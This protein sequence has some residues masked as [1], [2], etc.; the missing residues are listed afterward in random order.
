MPLLAQPPTNPTA[1]GA[2]RPLNTTH[3]VAA[4][5]YLL[6]S[7]RPPTLCSQLSPPPSPAIPPSP[8]VIEAASRGL[9]TGARAAAYGSGLALAGVALGSLWAARSISGVVGENED[10]IDS[11]GA[12]AAALKQT[13][14]PLGDAARDVLGPVA[15]W[16]RRE[17]GGGEEGEGR[18][19][20]ARTKT[21]SL[22]EFGASLGRRLDSSRRK[23]ASRAGVGGGGG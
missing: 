5:H 16:A 9:A 2:S 22:D 20:E 1:A 7:H 18:G 15:S 23:W 17:I 8:A 12:S 14:L 4:S 19:K 13:L 3:T 6:V 11:A 10:G 21:Q